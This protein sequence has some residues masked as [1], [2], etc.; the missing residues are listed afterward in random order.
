MKKIVIGILA[1]VDA[2]KTTLSEAF[3]YNTGA[4]RNLGRV[5]NRDTFLDTDSVE[6]QRGITVFSKQAVFEAN[7]TYITLLDTPGH[8]DFSAETERT[9]SVL[10]AAILLVSATDGVDGHTLLLWRALKHYNVPTFIFVNKT[11]MPGVDRAEVLRQ[12]NAKFGEGIVDFSKDDRDE[13][14]AMC[15][16]NLMN[17]YLSG[18]TIEDDEI[19]K[20]VRERKLYPVFYGSALRNDGVNEL[21]SNVCKYAPAS[22]NDSPEFGARVFKITRDS[23]GERLTHALITS[24]RCN[25]KEIVKGSNDKINQIRFYSGEKFETRDYAEAGEICAFTGL[26]DTRTGCGL[27]ITESEAATPLMTPVQSYSFILP[28]EVS[29]VTFFPKI[30]M[31]E[32]EDPTLTVTKSEDGS[33]IGISVMG[34]VGLEILKYKIKERFDINVDFGPG[35]VLYKETIAAPVE[36]VGHY[37][38]LRHYAEVH[39]L[40]EP[41]PRGAGLS[42]ETNVSTDELDLNWQRLIMTHLREKEHKGV[43]IGAPITDMKITLVAGRAHLKHTEGGDF[44][45]ATYRAIRQGLMKAE[46]ILLEPVYDFILNVPKDAVG[47]AMSDLERMNAKINIGTTDEEGFTVIEGRAPVALLANYDGTLKSYTGG[48]G[49]ITCTPSGYEPCHNGAE[50]ME[51]VAYNPEADIENSPDSVFCSHGAGTTIPWYETEKYM[52]LP[53]YEFDEDAYDY[54]DD[55]EEYEAFVVP[56]FEGPSERFLGTDEIDRIINSSV[57]ANAGSNKKG[58]VGYLKRRIRKPES[59]REYKEKRETVYKG[60]PSKKPYMLVDGYNV[61]FAWNELKELADVN[62]DSARDRL[63]DI[64]S[65]YKA[66]INAELILVFDAY[67]VKGGA[68]HTFDYHNIHIVYTKEAQTADQYIEKFAHENARNY[69]ITVVTSDGLEQI[70]IRG[71][72]CK[73]ISSREFEHEVAAKSRELSEKYG[74]K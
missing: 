20:L 37:E 70:I 62:I 1:H 23:K 18:A 28:P 73:L 59:K 4:I 13:G 6:R 41:M 54:E 22:G 14:I 64:L 69:D 5:D 30:K 26:T 15:D 21:L 8:M 17:R 19:G 12:I 27:G 3:L 52:H 35:R 40:L 61:I 67:K 34:E 9:L 57:G 16:E 11:D 31:M 43:L 24:G 66:M 48:K 10:S 32:D 46:N 72:G 50:V 56:K 53:A 68:Q 36:G 45:Q 60:A 74:L 49:S 71:E 63:R 25:V 55:E 47:R 29:P 51:S 65:N 7:D 44:R 58:S 33:T 39:L 38:P 42:F 2:G